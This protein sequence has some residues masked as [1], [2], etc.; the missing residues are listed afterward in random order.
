MKHKIYCA[1]INEKMVGARNKRLVRR[2]QLTLKR[3]VR[4]NALL[5]YGVFLCVY[6]KKQSVIYD[7]PFE[8]V[9][10]RKRNKN[11]I[12]QKQGGMSNMR[13]E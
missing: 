4:I 1:I 2:R 10:L 9:E 5:I 3:K 8:Q 13:N 7:I 6:I 11:K 12:E